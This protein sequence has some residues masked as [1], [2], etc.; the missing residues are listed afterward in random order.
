MILTAC[1]VIL[2]DSDSATWYRR[3]CEAVEKMFADEFTCEP[4]KYQPKQ[5]TE[6]YSAFQQ[7]L[8]SETYLKL[9]AKYSVIPC[10]HRLMTAVM[11]VIQKKIMK[12]KSDTVNLQPVNQ[13]IFPSIETPD[14]D[15]GRGKV[16]YVGGYCVAK[17]RHRLC[18]T[19]RNNLFKPG[20][21]SEVQKLNEQ[22][23]LLDNVVTSAAEISETSNFPETL[24]ETYR[25]QNIREGLTNI[26]DGAF[27]FFEKLEKHAAQVMTFENL[28]TEKKFLFRTVLKTIMDDTALL[29]SFIKN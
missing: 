27:Q 21:E 18:S 20:M 4:G 29:E 22:I 24:K 1:H 10:G 15:A 8:S 5:F 23:N 17:C 14:S 11:F 13:N 9:T 12:R 25:K 6:F 26:S 19:M 28:Q 16:R 2:R 7:Y 3:Q